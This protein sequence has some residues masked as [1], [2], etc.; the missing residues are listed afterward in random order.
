[1]TAWE[2]DDSISQKM[3]WAPRSGLHNTAAE[4]APNKAVAVG[5]KAHKLAYGV[6]DADFWRER[7]AHDARTLRRFSPPDLRY[8]TRGA[9]ESAR[10][11][12]ED[13]KAYRDG[14]IAEHE[15]LAREQFE[16]ERETARRIDAEYG[17]RGGEVAHAW[18]GTLLS[19]RAL[20]ASLLEALSW[21]RSWRKKG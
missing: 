9:W 21:N 11:L 13:G 14:F 16:R 18:R 10:K 6:D 3:H 12:R 2:S 15:R 5:E 20:K 4:V 8:S 17:W 1:M 19:R 7:G